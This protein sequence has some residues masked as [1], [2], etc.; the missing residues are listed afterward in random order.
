MRNVRSM[1]GDYFLYRFILYLYF[2]AAK[3]P[4]ARA[5]TTK[6]APAP[7][8]KKEPVSPPKKG[9]KRA[10]AE[11]VDISSNDPESEDN[12]RSN[13]SASGSSTR[14]YPVVEI[15]QVRRSN[16]G[17]T[18][19]SSKKVRIDPPA[20]QDVSSILETQFIIVAD[21]LR[22]MGEAAEAFRTMSEV[23]GKMRGN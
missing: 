17:Q 4:R 21:A 23:I 10:Y 5:V 18:A 11:T 7:R 3:R 2:T 9:G 19:G 22:S 6:K 20:D 15:P 12:K 13:P 14:L 1:V 16:R 8:I